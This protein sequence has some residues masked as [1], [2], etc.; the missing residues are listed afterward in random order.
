MGQLENIQPTVD[1]A[2]LKSMGIKPKTPVLE[3]FLQL[4]NGSFAIH[5]IIATLYR[6]GLTVNFTE[7]QAMLKEFA[8]H[9]IFK[10]RFALPLGVFPD[11]K[12]QYRFQNKKQND[13]GRCIENLLLIR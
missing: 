9:N 12:Y 8:K 1:T 11:L 7:L 10:K 2:L 5:E 13:F 6:K 3:A 4:C